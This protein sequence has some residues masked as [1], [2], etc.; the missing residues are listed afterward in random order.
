MNKFM[1]RYFVVMVV[2]VVLLALGG[3]SDTER[4]KP[5]SVEQNQR[6]IMMIGITGYKRLHAVKCYDAVVTR[7]NTGKWSDAYCAGVYG[8]L[9]IEAIKYE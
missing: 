1:G 6:I 3:C 8:H 7:V 9:S 4:V 5:L 2:V